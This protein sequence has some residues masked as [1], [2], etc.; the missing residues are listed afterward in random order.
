[1]G[2]HR[3]QRLMRARRLFCASSLIDSATSE[4]QE[5]CDESQPNDDAFHDFFLQKA[6]QSRAPEVGAKIEAL[7]QREALLSSAAGK[8][9]LCTTPARERHH[10]QRGRAVLR[11]GRCLLDAGNQGAA[12]WPSTEARIEHDVDEPPV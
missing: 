8:G 11:R 4:R 6:D 10:L 2:S 12:E 9:R 1:A 5:R 3:A 7:S